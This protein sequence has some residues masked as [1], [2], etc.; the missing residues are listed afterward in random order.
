MNK[1][2]KKVD[3]MEDLKDTNQDKGANVRLNETK[4]K[5]L[6]EK[7]STRITGNNLE[8]RRKKY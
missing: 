4:K 7:K 5:T 3:F 6:K 2:K 1:N 8:K